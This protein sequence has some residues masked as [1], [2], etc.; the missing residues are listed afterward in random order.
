MESLQPGWFLKGVRSHIDES[1]NSRFVSR[2]FLQQIVQV[3]RPAKLAT[4]GVLRG[5]GVFRMV[6]N[7]PWR[8]Q[9]LLILCYHGTSLEDEHLWR[10]SLYIHPQK[11]EQ[12]LESLKKGQFS[13]LPLGEALQRLR[14]GALPSRSVAFT[15]DDGTYDFFGRAYPL[16]KDY[17]FPATVYQTTYYISVERPVFHLICSY[18]LWKRRG[19]VISDGGEV[20][21][22]GPL[23]LRTDSSRA[24]ILRRLIEVSE[25]ESRTALQKDE[26]AA[27]LARVLEIDYDDLKAKRILQLMNGREL[28][29]I[30]RNG[31]DV[32]LH[33]HRH[34]TP[35]EEALFRREI[36]ENR[37]RIHELTATQPVHF[38]YP[39]GV[40]RPA[41]LPWL[42]KEHVVSATTCDAGLATR[43]SESL[44]LPRFIDN[45]NRLQIEFES[46]VTGVGDLL[47]WRRMAA[48]HYIPNRS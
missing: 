45:Q 22:P 21:L 2:G 13:V 41:F 1:M 4:L 16:L 44:L 27:Q 26:I 8:R 30:A 18:M 48:Q 42:R 3:L 17:G 40:Y 12:R 35:E 33:T 24:E 29:E 28:R 36:Q 23:D 7:S 15:F 14:A 38:C 34:R 43:Q 47:A 39:S 25:R 11:L 5:S 32:Q 9:R 31:I 6:A 19:E 10:P 46:W 37:S 20:G